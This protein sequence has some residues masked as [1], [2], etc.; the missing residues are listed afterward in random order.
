MAKRELT[1]QQQIERSII[2][3]YRSKLWAPF[4][5]AIKDYELIKPND[6][7][8]A[9]ISGGKD[10]MLLAKLFQELKKHSDFDFEVKYLVMN[11]GYNEANLE[12]TKKNLEI[13]GI[14]AV[15]VETNIFE[16]ANAQEKNMC[17][18]C[19]KMRRG[20]LYRIA[21]DMGC[22]KIALGHHYDDVIETILMNMLNTGSFQTMLPKLHSDNYEGMELIRPLYLI[23]EKDIKTWAK[24]NGL[25]FLMCACRFTEACSV[26]N[27]INAS[28]RLTTKNLIQELKKHYSDTVEEN[29]FSAATNVNMDKIIGYKKDGIRHTFLEEYEK[30]DNKK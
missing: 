13:L 17:Y 28:K 6:V 20:A 23:R 16:V 3:T 2:T 14:P 21:Q 24:A 25:R 15:I 22:N 10:S 1:R 7:V 11:P 29:I 12:Y 8:C 19:A 26:D 18:L 5:K 27:E 30:K 9:C 4:I